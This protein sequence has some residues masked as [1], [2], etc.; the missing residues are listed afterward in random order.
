[1]RAFEWDAEIDIVPEF[2]A[3]EFLRLVDDVRR[4]LRAAAPQTPVDIGELKRVAREKLSDGH[5]DEAV[6]DL[7]NVPQERLDPEAWDLLAKAFDA[8]GR[9]D[10]AAIARRAAAGE[11]PP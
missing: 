11:R 4:T 2:Y 8:Q 9:G 6:Y 7:M 5:A 3:P 1:K 10:P